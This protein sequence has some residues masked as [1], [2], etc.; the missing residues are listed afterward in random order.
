MNCKIENE[1]L[2]VEIKPKG[3]ELASVIHKQ[4]QLQYMWSGDPA[5][6]GKTSPVLFPIV[7]TLK[8][9][10]YIYKDKKYSLPRHGF[11]RDHV[12]EVEKQNTDNI[13]FLLKSSATTLEKYPFHFELRLIY[14]LKEDT[15]QL[16][17]DIRNIGGEEMYFSIGAHPAF[18]VPLVKS[19]VYEDHYLEFNQE[20]T[21]GRWPISKEG[22]IKTEPD[23]FFDHTHV[24]NLT[25]P[26][27]YD[28]ALV[29]KHLKSNSISLK[30]KTHSHGLDFYFEGFPFMGIWG[31]KDADFVCIEPWCGI[32][33]GVN[34]NQ[35]LISKEGIEKLASNDSWS[36]AWKVRFY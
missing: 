1:Y 11:A 6:W 7:G 35:Q 2:V 31:A 36:R 26:L 17:Y 5:V 9:D 3:A 30:S 15:L 12:F 18:A 27:F 13:T 24:I 8:E 29:F 25:K 34:H 14:T 23:K 21:A 28:D 10:T 4:N 16:Q 22:L 19:S 32:A 33:D 20:E